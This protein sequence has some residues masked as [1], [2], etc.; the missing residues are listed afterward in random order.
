MMTFQRLTGLNRR[1]SQ[2]TYKV[3]VNRF[4][5]GPDPTRRKRVMMSRPTVTMAVMT[6]PM[7]DPACHSAKAAK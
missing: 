5:R 4:G 3:Q 6:Q 1:V 7:L 2:E